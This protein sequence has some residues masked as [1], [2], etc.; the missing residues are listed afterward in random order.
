[1]NESLQPKKRR[2][3]AARKG[4]FI[5]EPHDID[6]LLGWDKENTFEQMERMFS[7]AANDRR[8][9]ERSKENRKRRAPRGKIWI[10]DLT[11]RIYEDREKR[12]N[13]RTLTRST[14]H[15]K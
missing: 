10:S 4:K 13:S 12:E 7:A 11:V 8:P 15:L 1:M 14:K 6:I 2:R 5:G 3:M 9:M